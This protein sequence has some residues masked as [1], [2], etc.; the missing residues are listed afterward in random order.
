MLQGFP[1]SGSSIDGSISRTEMFMR[2]S[3]TVALRSTC[4]REQVGAI[5]VVNDRPISM[6]YNGAPSGLPHCLEVGC[7]LH[8]G[9][10]IRTTHADIN[11]IT[12]AARPGIPIEGG[13]V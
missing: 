6:G 11:A 10:S 13:I 12:L 2:I 9:H 8:N 1:T 5:V 4:K 7:L 3:E